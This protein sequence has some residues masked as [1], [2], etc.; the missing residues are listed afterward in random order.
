MG[1]LGRSIGRASG[2]S[3]FADAEKGFA[4]ADQA[5]AKLAAKL[6]TLR[7]RYAAA[8]AAGVKLNKT[9]AAIRTVGKQYE[10][11]AGKVVAMRKRM[12]EAAEAAKKKLGET[13]NRVMGA[14]TAAFAAATVGLRALVSQFSPA[15][16]TRFDRAMS[17]LYATLGAKLEPVL[18][19]VTAAI[20]RVTHWIWN[21][22]AGVT[23]TIVAFAKWAAASAVIVGA[24]AAVVKVG[25]FLKMAYGGMAAAATVA[26]GAVRAGAAL[27]MPAV[28]LLSSAFAAI[29]AILGGLVT[30][31]QGAFALVGVA[32][33][34]VGAAIVAIG[35]TVAAVTMLFPAMKRIAGAALEGVGKA[36]AKLKNA[37]KGITN[38][39]GGK[40]GAA[41]GTDD[42]RAA[43]EK[44]HAAEKDKAKRDIANADAETGRAG[45]A[46]AAA[47]L[48]GN[49]DAID[50]AHD[51]LKRAAAKRA[52]GEKDLA[53]ADAKIAADAK[54]DSSPPEGPRQAS[55][56]SGVEEIGK[57]A[58][59]SALNSQT[60]TDDKA[61]AKQ[62]VALLQ[63][64]LAEQRAARAVAKQQGADAMKQNERGKL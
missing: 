5:A 49:Q 6:T 36:A 1:V 62:Q 22:P 29:P 17:S 42:A 35:T 56:M 7:Q 15:S 58:R 46:L 14:A 30:A 33:G 40:G 52:K 51:A 59:L 4:S 50:A 45:A 10:A 57:A 2:G 20:R 47:T 9:A 60:G 44:K 63:A 41:A 54:R 32:L 28:S 48:I 19:S 11:A 34:P 53:G 18:D 37:F 24:M 21:L 61:L 3:D 16:A 55:Y 64:M 25:L 8:A 13:L 39:F 43:A 31:A 26:F 38:A 27:V 12:D 23:D